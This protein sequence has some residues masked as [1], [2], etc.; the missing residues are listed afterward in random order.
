MIA[1]D[2]SSI[3]GANNDPNFGIRL[4]AAYDS[5]GHL[6][7]EFASSTLS[8]GQTVQY[9]GTS[10]NWRFDNLTVSGTAVP[11]P[12]RHR[13]GGPRSTGRWLLR[14]AS[15]RWPRLRY[16]PAA[17]CNVLPRRDAHHFLQ[18]SG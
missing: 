10:G 1:I 18:H 5:T 17:R 11:E 9:N 8:S 12:S 13:V 3:A 6:G 2:L 15:P 16:G 14:L 4:V 7:N